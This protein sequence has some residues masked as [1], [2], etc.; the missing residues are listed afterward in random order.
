MNVAQYIANFLA[1]HGTTDSFGIPGGVILDII[2][3]FDECDGIT[4][5]LTYH[6]QSAGFAACAYAQESG[7]LG[8]AYAT[9]GPGFTNL[10]SSIA[11]A[12][13]DSIPVLFIVGHASAK[14]DSNMRVMFDQELD[15]CSMIKNITKY[16]VRVE[17]VENVIECLNEA[18]T[19]A[20]DGRKG[21]VFLDISSGILKKEV[22]YK[23]VVEAKCLDHNVEDY[24]LLISEQIKNAKR[25]VILIGDGI[26]Q[27]R[28]ENEFLSFIE[29]THIP[30][31]S[32]R[33]SH[34]V[35]NKTN[36]YYGY[37]GSH[38]IRTANFI[39]SKSD[40][41]ISIGNRLH[42][43]LKSDSFSNIMN[44]VK[45]IRFD[46]DETEL[47]RQIPG[48]DCH[49]TDITCLLKTLSKSSNDYGNYSDWIKT[50]DTL[51]INLADEDVNDAVRTV[52]NILDNISTDVIIT[53]DVGNNEFWVSR[54][55]V[56]TGVK[57]RVLYS[58]SFGAL[59]CG[60]GKAI[61]GYYASHKSVLCF[62]G[63]QGI[64][65][66]IQELMFISQHKLP[67]A[68]I[69]LN[70]HSSGM[71]KDRETATKK[72]KFLHTT[73]DSDY[74]TPDFCFL[75]RSYDL[76]YIK[77]SGDINIYDIISNIKEPILIDVDIDENDELTPSLPKGQPFQNLFPEL[78]QDKYK[79][80]ND[81]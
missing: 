45:I 43:P 5:H 39:L 48:S 55:C 3:A 31:V 23:E 2:Y 14:L 6:E 21:P 41:I 36:L 60:L 50:C 56:L 64:Q 47:D 40:L 17:T 10:I 19:I 72:H 80:L 1:K 35:G 7:K 30:C 75:A 51:R 59:G 52:A 76:N 62:V 32:S 44:N 38:G 81:L 33:Y 57:N 16:A 61:G 9:R 24:S 25:P 67:I 22:N 8:V 13:C 63:D 12:Y 71:I 74:G 65:M 20:M 27:A 42:Y 34:N 49:I 18:Y 54:A 26:N 29:R 15:T 73:I 68:I 58:K 53:T 46:V 28:Q 77:L 4:P 78:P 69:L 79:Y 37:I 66:N 11:D 70:N